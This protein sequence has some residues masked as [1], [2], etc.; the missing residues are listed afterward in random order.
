MLCRATCD[1]FLVF[2]SVL[3]AAPSLAAQKVGFLFAGQGSDQTIGSMPPF[4]LI[5]WCSAWPVKEKLLFGRRE[6]VKAAARSL[7]SEDAR[8]VSDLLR[9]GVLKG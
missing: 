2:L 6:Q 5:C 3:I 1:V 9:R 8:E 7:L 4:F